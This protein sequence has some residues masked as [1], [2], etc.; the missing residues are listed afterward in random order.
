M[1]RSNSVVLKFFMC[2]VGQLYFS[3]ANQVHKE[4]K[5]LKVINID[6]SSYLYEGYNTNFG[7]LTL[8]FVQKFIT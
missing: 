5:S 1:S 2:T 4:S 3:T 8:N 6:N 7:P